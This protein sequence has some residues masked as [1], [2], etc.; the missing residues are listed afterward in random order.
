MRTVAKIGVSSRI[1]MSVSMISYKNSLFSQKLTWLKT[2]HLFQTLILLI[3]TL[4]TKH[5]PCQLNAV[6]ILLYDIKNIKI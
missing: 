5:I 3:A 2:K 4:S 6:Y 1:T